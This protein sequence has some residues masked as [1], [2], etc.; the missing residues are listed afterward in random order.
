M[1][2]DTQTVVVMGVVIGAIIQA[3]KGVSFV[4]NN[5]DVLP[6]ASLVVG[7]LVGFGASF[8]LNDVNWIGGLFAGLV[9]S[10]GYESIQSVVKRIKSKPVVHA[11]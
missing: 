10:G 3:V 8:V 5:K 6:L 1:N 9:A 4:Q 2:L 7:G 11:E